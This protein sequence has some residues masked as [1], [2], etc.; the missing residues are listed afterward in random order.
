V[1]VGGGV[2]GLSTAWH[3]A[4]RG[5]GPLLLEAEQIGSG[6]SG[7]TGGLVL[8]GTAWGTLP[9]TERV[10]E[11]LQEVVAALETDCQLRL[12]GCDLLRHAPAPAGHPPRWQDSGTPLG[13]VAQ[14]PGGTIDP[15]A[16]L[17]GLARAAVA[18]G[19]TL[20]ERTP[21]LG[22]ET[23]RVITE[24]GAISCERIVMAVNAWVS[25]LFPDEAPCRVALTL[26]LATEPLTLSQLT[27]IDLGHGRPFYTLDR[28]YLW[29]RVLG[30]RRVV[31]GAGLVW[32]R[33][34]LPEAVRL[35]E[36]PAR[37]G[38]AWLEGRVRGLHPRLHDIGVS[39]R[40]GGPIAFPERQA[41]LLAPAPRREG[42][43]LA[44]GCGGHGLALG[45]H[46]GRLLAAAVA[47]DAPLPPWGALP[48]DS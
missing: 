16:L 9:G 21:V 8:E 31:F 48:A 6:A 45:V 15:G 37:E 2:A 42:V 33:D 28:P 35:S 27:A 38:L 26:A 24:R 7:R 34:G 32:A 10:L 41:P 29:G 18:A 17:S 25:R 20:C 5:L 43:F 3:L 47:D 22:V 30:D 13:V 23:G 46:L 36:P 11:T 39:A 4:R 44:A 19:A 1:I 14:E 12:P 40:W